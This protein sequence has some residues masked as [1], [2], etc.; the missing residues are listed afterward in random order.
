[1]N[2]D[3]RRLLRQYDS[4]AN[5]DLYQYYGQGQAQLLWKRAT[6]PAVIVP[7][8]I[9]ALTLL[10]QHRG[11]PQAPGY[12]W[13][14]LV[15]IT[16][17]RLLFAI[18][19]WLN[20]PLF[21]LPMLQTQ[22][23]THAAKSEVLRRVLGLDKPGGII[24][25]VSRVGRMGINGLSGTA[26]GTKTATDQPAG[27]GNY[28]NSCYQNSILQSLA[29]LKSFPAYLS[30]LT[31]GESSERLPT[32]T[33]DALR[34][35]ITDLTNASNNGRTLWTPG[36]LKNMSSWQ[37]QDA[38]EYFSKL[39][40]NIDKEIA[41]VAGAR[42]K[43][44]GLE[45]DWAKDDASSSQHSDDSGYHSQ[46]S[47]SR[48]GFEPRSIRNP[49]VG[50]VAQRVAC[51]TCGYCEG[52]S[53]IPFN[54]LTLNLGVNY[55]EHNLYEILDSYTKVEPIQGVECAKCTLLKRL[56]LL[57]TLLQ[58]NRDAGKADEDLPGVNERVAAVE[59]ALE[60]DAF[61][62][63]TLRNKCKVPARQMSTSTK[64][65]QAV[66]ARP[67]QS[68][69][70]HMNRSVFDETSGRMSKNMSAVRFPMT[71]DLGPWCLGSADKL[72]EQSD[73]MADKSIEDGETEADSR[74]E[75]QW[76]LEPTLSMVAGTR[77]R[78]KITGPIYE[79]RAVITHY[80]RH[81]NGHYVCYRRHPPSSETVKREPVDSEAAGDAEQP[82]R[83]ASDDD[84]A[85]KGD[86]EPAPETEGQSQWW[87]LSDQTV[88]KV[89]ESTVLAQGGV[90]M[91]FYDC[92]DPASVQTSSLDDYR[93][94]S[95]QLQDDNIDSLASEATITPLH[96]DLPEECGTDETTKP[97]GTGSNAAT[98]GL[99]EVLAAAVSIPLPPEEADFDQDIAID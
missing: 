11:L 7:V 59:E 76:L 75:E 78:S 24:S 5:P 6:S 71:L 96:Q 86:P 80:G 66:I 33:V 18:D 70:V 65:K 88:T 50:L 87:R 62:E 19:R 60:D 38:Q 82:P 99:G 44:P 56:H 92:I 72:T 20:P 97:T 95:Q 74:D 52:L 57:K 13:D 4:Y 45:Q 81:E 9:L 37:Q 90:F 91:L 10:L 28:D 49:L 54:C 69:A 34:D 30:A 84:A 36:A 29:A 12:L 83:L 26:L 35:L 42:Y 94:A 41:K 8:I 77:H 85:D 51:V 27:L 63:D 22:S 61:D 39:L 32:G 17:S 93:D 67:P 1:M 53:M 43:P 21:P 46:S 47:H 98:E 79:L 89:Y 25:S 2:S 3:T 73:A 68:L 23:R 58:R 55:T 16:P 48:A 15:A 40:D 14:R 64:T 31:D